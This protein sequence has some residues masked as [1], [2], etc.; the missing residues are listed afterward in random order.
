MTSNPDP[1]DGE[2]ITLTCTSST[3]EVDS[4]TWRR[5]GVDIDMQTS[6]TYAIP[7]GDIATMN[8]DYTCVALFGTVASD[9]SSAL[10]VSCKYKGK[11]IFLARCIPFFLL[12]PFY[13]KSEKLPGLDVL[14]HNGLFG[15]RQSTLRFFGM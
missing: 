10:T 14:L 13:V 7:Q 6:Q 2:D 11:D 8:G 3:T 4:Y 9:A 15:S 5:N 1:T 12:N